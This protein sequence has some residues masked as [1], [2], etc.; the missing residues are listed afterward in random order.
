MTVTIRPLT[1]SGTVT[2]GDSTPTA[3][4]VMAPAMPPSRPASTK[5]TAL[6]RWTSMPQSRAATSCWDTARVAS[7]SR[8]R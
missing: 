2:S 3:A 8:L 1:V 4:A 7:P 5:V 6:V